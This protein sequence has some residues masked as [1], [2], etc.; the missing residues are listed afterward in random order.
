MSST[1][2]AELS[3]TL[4]ADLGSDLL[5]KSANFIAEIAPLFQAAFGIYVLFVIY[6]YYGQSGMVSFADFVKR[7]CGWVVLI[8]LAFSPSLYMKLAQTIYVLPDEFASLF[9]GQ[10][11]DAS[12][13]DAAWT[14]VQKISDKISE[15]HKNYTWMD[16][17]MH[18]RLISL[19]FWVTLCA[20]ATVGVAF[21]F[22]MVAKI[23]LALVLMLGAF[24]IGC[25]LF[26][27]TRQYGMNWIGQC[28]NY[29]VTCSMLVL[30]T[31]VQMQ[32]FNKVIQT[33]A[34]GDSGIFDAIAMEAVIPVLLLLTV[35]FLIIIWCIPSIASA[36]TG[37]A[38]VQA[39]ARNVAAMA[40]G[41]SRFVANR[42]ANGARGGNGKSGGGTITTAPS[43]PR[44]AS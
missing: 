33:A 40:G 32:A 19:K 36:L 27:S 39:M 18:M 44:R 1:F 11:F 4:G 7:A 41:T 17:H 13:M 34:T 15:L 3:Q 6:D 21:A 22:Y 35:I 29:I 30:A 10:K 24:F 28:L 42:G 20:A 26:P 31:A 12:A 25:L 16:I 38:A 9:S 5:S 8:G 23:S 2:F 14:E 43:R 37:G